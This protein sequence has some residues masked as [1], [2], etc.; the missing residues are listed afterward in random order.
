MRT[1]LWLLGLFAV[2]VGLTL[3]SKYSAGYVLFVV[4]PYRAEISINLLVVLLFAGFLA[5]YVFVRLAAH[6]LRLPSL[7]REFREQ[8]SREKAREQML[9]GLTAFFEGRYARARKAAANALQ[10]KESPALNAVIAARSAHELRQFDKRDEYLAQAD[11]GAAN[12]ATMGLVTRAELLLKQRRHDEALRI[13]KTLR[14]QM[15]RPHTAALRLELKAQQQARNWDAV[16]ELVAQ[17]DSRN[18]F[19]Q[20]LVKQLRRTA[21]VENLR[22]KALNTRALEEYWQKLTA[23]ERKDGKIAATAAQAYMALG[24]CLTAHQIIEPALDNEWSAELIT[25]YGEC[26]GQDALKQIEWAEGWLKV[27]PQD[28]CLLLTLGKLCAY[29]G[30]WGKAQSYLE[31]SLSVESNHSAHLALAQLYEQTGK[32]ELAARHYRESLDMTLVQLRGSTG[33]RRRSAL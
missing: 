27:H 30:L 24:G 21:H 26:F 20:E 28:P 4:P 11:S 15:S 13:L 9:A 5:A 12:D 29:Q 25:L 31:A 2:A 22:R 6:T 33:G 10:L 1:A 18:A 32:P 8:R 16:L 14:Q 19:D 17:L 3:A 7:V 23:A